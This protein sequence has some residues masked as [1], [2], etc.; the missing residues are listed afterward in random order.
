MH[1]IDN[2]PPAQP[3]KDFDEAEF[4]RRCID[5]YNPKS[6]C[7][8]RCG[9]KIWK[10][11]KTGSYKRSITYPYN[12]EPRT[13]TIQIPLYLCEKC[14]K[15]EDG[16]GCENGDYHHAT[17]PNNLIPF[18]TFTLLFVLTVLHESF[19]HVRTVQEIC[20]HWE[21][22]V[23]TLYAWRHRYRQHY[24][25]WVD[26]FHSIR[27]YEEMITASHDD[28]VSEESNESHPAESTCNSPLVQS[29]NWVFNHLS[30]IVSGF[31]LRFLFSF[32]QG[33]RRT[34]YRELPASR[35]PK[36]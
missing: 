2:I 3:N 11:E 35:R 13:D 36:K 6:H 18:T 5:A 23:N 32:M 26:T 33:C 31:F 20:A 10:G 29:I 21:I 12:G 22:S 14:G 27:H 15:S 19:T 1:R 24:D 17:L 9:N 34:H 7:C 25:A 8:G 28:K 30:G 4:T 16:S